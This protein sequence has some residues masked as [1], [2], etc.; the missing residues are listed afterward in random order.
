MRSLL[1]FLGLSGLFLIAAKE[2]PAA[3][4]GSGNYKAGIAVKVITPQEGLWMAGYAGRKKPAEGKVHDLKVKALALE[5]ANGKKLVLLTSDLLGLSRALSDEIAEEV[6][7]KAKLSREQ[8]M[9]TSSHT[10][11]GP[12]L[13]GLLSDMYEMPP[14]QPKLIAAYTEGLKASIVTTILAALDDLKPARLA[15]GHGKAGFVMNRRQSTDKGVVIG[16]NPKGPVDPDVPVLRVETP[17]GK[18]RAVVLGYACHN[19]TLDFYKWCGDYAG[20]AQAMIEADYP[21]AVAMFWSGCGGDAN[22]NPRGKLEQAEQHGR[23]LADAVESVL[24]K[25]MK[26]LQ[27]KFTAK[28]ERISL[29]L[30]DLGTKEKLAERLD[31]DLSSKQYAVRTRANRLKKVLDSGGKIDDRYP[32]YPV[33]VWR[34]GDDLLWVAL[35]GEVVVDYALNLKKDLTGEKEGAPT[36]WVTAYAN[37]VMAYIPTAAILKE[38]G[39]EPDYSMIYYGFPGKWAPTIE[40]M[41]LDKVIS[42]SRR[43]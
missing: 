27:G 1:L 26:S 10:H 12:V 42:L 14:E 16:V 13:G 24:K 9:L 2:G 39:Y 33:Q 22:P 23:E 37:D 30:D 17:D 18:L 25:E 20:F 36:V 31:A 3:E 35:G 38:G 5:D 41:I 28:Y 19:T 43:P 29:A 4:A 11:C 15:I 7:K 40:N 32:Y 34:L 8:I 6:M 21:G